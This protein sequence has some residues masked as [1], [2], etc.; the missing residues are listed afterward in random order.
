MKQ[1]PPPT[2]RTPKLS[3]SFL[4][5]PISLPEEWKL[6]CLHISNGLSD[7]NYRGCTVADG[8]VWIPDKDRSGNVVFCILAEVIVWVSMYGSIQQSFRV[9]WAI[10][11]FHIWKRTVLFLYCAFTMRCNIE[12]KGVFPSLNTEL[13]LILTTGKEK[14]SLSLVVFSTATFTVGEISTVLS[15]SD[16]DAVRCYFVQAFIIWPPTDE[17][18]MKWKKKTQMTDGG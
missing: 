10:F 12:K 3:I 4:S 18:T 7:N 2:I 16:G 8:F 17:L 9:Y 14:W 13:F 6:R 15:I 11:Q 1:G 5:F